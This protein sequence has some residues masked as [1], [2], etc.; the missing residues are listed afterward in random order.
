M[1]TSPASRSA[2]A[3]WLRSL[4]AAFLVVTGVHLFILQPFVVP[5]S[6]MATT[7]VPGDYILVSKLHY[8]PQTP[9][10]VGIPFLN[11]YLPG[12]DLPAVRLPGFTDPERGD[13]A[14]FHYPPARKP[15]DQKTT[16]IKRL[17]GL[18]GDTVAVRQ[19]R[20]WV[21]G[22]RLALPPTIQHQWTVRLTDP[23]MQLTPAHLRP[24]GIESVR[25]TSDPRRRVLHATRRAARALEALPFVRDVALRA[26]P[27]D[28]AALF[29]A[30]RGYTPNAYGPMPVP[31]KNQ[32]VALTDSTWS[33]YQTL[34]RQHEGR[35]ATRVARGVFRIDGTVRAHYT[36]AQDYFFVM[37][38]HRD[39][40]LDSRFWGYVPEDHLVGE[41]VATL[42]S[43][44]GATRSLRWGRTLRPLE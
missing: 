16:Y 33:L 20:A 30:G 28:E 43:W 19:G 13:I 22:Q 23:R 32:T 6:S 21:N 31:R 36:F 2:V 26:A 39:N 15:V 8:G 42:F 5:T 44:D 9:H 4:L 37:G 24:L 3:E 17:I 35:E 11:L 29:P 40:S 7:I 10:S 1:H 34:I 18:P 14:V 38:D 25:R 27:A 12:V 41:A